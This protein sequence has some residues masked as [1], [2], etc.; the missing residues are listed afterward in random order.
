[1]T[2]QELQRLESGR[3]FLLEAVDA[4]REMGVTDEMVAHIMAALLPDYDR[5]WCRREAAYLEDKGLVGI[6]RHEVRSWRYRLTAAGRDVVDYVVECPA[7][8]FRPPPG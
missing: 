5:A 2:R 6:E 7:G 4:H 8:I 1:M 3:W